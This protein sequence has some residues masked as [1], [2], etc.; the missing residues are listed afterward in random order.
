[1][2]NDFI[3]NIKLDDESIHKNQNKEI[4][5]KTGFDLQSWDEIIGLQRKLNNEIDPNWQANKLDWKTAMVIESTELV[6]SINWKWWKNM[7]TDWANIEIEMIVLLHSIFAKSIELNIHSNLFGLVVVSETQ[8]QI[9]TKN[10]EL[11][12]EIKNKIINEFIG[13]VS[14]DD[15]VNSLRIWLEIWFT[16]GYS[17]IDIFKIYKMKYVLNNFRQDHGYKTGEYVKLWNG[18]EDNVIAQQLI[19]TIPYDDEFMNNL[20]IELDKEYLKNLSTVKNI[21]SFIKNNLKWNEFMIRVPDDD[22]KIFLEFAT[23]YANYM[24]S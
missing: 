13:F 17:S 24:E 12:N 11:A 19:T 23:E 3:N 22:R 7:S 15:M 4:F 18:K 8:K 20:Y 1:M 14:R 5:D 10:E 16:L 21:Q 6:D 9:R 2:K